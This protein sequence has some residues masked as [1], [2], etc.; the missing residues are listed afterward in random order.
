MKQG[1]VSGGGNFFAVGKQ[2]WSKVCAQGINP[3]TAFLVLARGSGGDQSTTRW[4][5]EAVARYTGITW[6]RASDSIAT[7]VKTGLVHRSGEK[8]RHPTYKLATPE[9]IGDLIWLPNGLVTGV[10]NEIPPVTRL[11]QSQ[12]L[13]HL[14]AFVELYALHDLAGDGGLPRSLIQKRYGTRE[15]ICDLGQFRVYGFSSDQTRKCWCTGPLARFK[16]SKDKRGESKV[17]RFLSALESMGLLECVDYLAE[18]SDPEA[19]LIHPLGGDEYATEIAD[20]LFSFVESLPDA[21]N[22]ASEEFDYVIPVTRHLENAAV[23]GIFRLT[24]RPHTKATAA[25]HAKHRTTCT[26]FA[27]QYEKI[28]NG[29]FQGMGADIKG[30]QGS[31][32]GDQGV[33]M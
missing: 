12:E 5:A 27:A 3:A 31:I 8:G 29:E 18:G 32:K 16:D 30:Y 14:R 1:N 28:A 6:K 10:G 22:R 4:S 24:Y 25:W 21:F 23:V 13:D 19:E 17:W 15:Q 11:R 2:Q 9:D 20:A 26:G 33:S 7:L